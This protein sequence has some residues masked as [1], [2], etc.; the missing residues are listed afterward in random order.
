[1]GETI[2]SNQ[3]AETMRRAARR[4]RVLMRSAWWAA[5]FVLLWV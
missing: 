2:L 5:S 1:M 3:I 4:P